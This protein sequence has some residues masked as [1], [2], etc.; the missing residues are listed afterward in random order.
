M[1][2][3]KS[4]MAIII[5]HP[6]ALYNKHLAKFGSSA[7][8]A[9]FSLAFETALAHK[10]D[11]DPILKQWERTK[12]KI[13]LES[14]V[15]LY[16]L[17]AKLTADNSPLIR[18]ENP[19]RKIVTDLKQ[20]QLDM[21][22]QRKA[23]ESKKLV[24]KF[25]KLTDE[26]EKFR[27]KLIKTEYYYFTPAH[28]L[29]FR[30][31]KP[32][33]KHKDPGL[34][35]ANY[36]RAL[37][38]EKTVADVGLDYYPAGTLGIM[39]D[40]YIPLLQSIRTWLQTHTELPEQE[41]DLIS[42]LFEGE[43]KQGFAA[44]IS[45]M[46]L[47]PQ[48][49]FCAAMNLWV[50]D[51]VGITYEANDRDEN[52]LF[53]FLYLTSLEVHDLPKNKQQEILSKLGDP[54]MYELFFIDRR[55]NISKLPPQ[56]HPAIFSYI[57]N[58]DPTFGEKG[59]PNDILKFFTF[60][61]TRYFRTKGIAPYTIE[62]AFTIYSAFE[63]IDYLEEE[64]D[65]NRLNLIV[66]LAQCAHPLDAP[67]NLLKSGLVPYPTEL[68]QKEYLSLYKLARV[69]CLP[70]LATAFLSFYFISN[71][72]LHE[73]DVGT[74][75]DIYPAIVESLDA[76]SSEL[77]QDALSYASV[78]ANKYNKNYISIRID[79]CLK[80]YP[81]VEKSISQHPSLHRMEAFAAYTPDAAHS[82]LVQK[83]GVEN[84]N[85][86]TERTRQIWIAA[87]IKIGRLSH[88]IIFDTTSEW[89]NNAAELIKPIENELK[90]RLGDIYSDPAY[91]NYRSR[92]GRNNPG[93]PT[94]GS[95]LQLLGEYDRLPESLRSRMEST[96]SLHKNRPLMTRL[97]KINS[98]YRNPGVHVDVFPVN[99][100]HAL[101]GELYS[102]GDLYR[103]FLNALH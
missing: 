70:E 18:K 34:I 100:L 57:A 78:I 103:D 95:L 15:H 51:R 102:E 48:P 21:D 36:L 33:E 82:F 90:E 55:H 71:A 49:L 85:K 29:R 19:E 20:P 88:D 56:Y 46:F 1:R 62:D 26:S 81:S 63:L 25:I 64:E 17:L 83:F 28:E 37:Y 52:L 89:G 9:D 2:N 59:I 74:W 67:I 27:K 99:K 93:T 31:D 68:R 50:S 45:A 65:K 66:R 87:H 7:D 96:S 94:F 12:S 32:L 13:S 53:L 38:P 14:K 4:H 79:A 39:H 60:S 40:D 101:I 98:D 92:E 35:I 24:E 22:T 3:F 75:N 16:R 58:D 41:Q 80:E 11:V 44:F 86:L 42:F 73:G 47:A 76:T 5:D 6:Q 10:L 8:L 43:W 54:S 61:G 23:E 97:R 84:L 77:I 69:E 72:V 91:R 30:L